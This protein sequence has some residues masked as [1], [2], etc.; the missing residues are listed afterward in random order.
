MKSRPRFTNNNCNK[1]SNLEKLS[2]E[3]PFSEEEIKR[4]IWN[5]GRNKAPGPNGYS[6]KFIKMFWDVLK[7]DIF[8]FVQHFGRTEI[9]LKGCNSSFI[10]LSQ[11]YETLFHY[12]GYKILDASIKFW[13]NYLLE[14]IFSFV[15]HYETHQSYRMLV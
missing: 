8:S 12:L 15:N 1:L 11:R 2:L 14:D 13:V 6:F 3:V 7:E 9:I 5:C 4:S 10:S